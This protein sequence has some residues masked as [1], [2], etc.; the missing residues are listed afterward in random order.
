MSRMQQF[1]NKREKEIGI[2]ITQHV[3]CVFCLPRIVFLFLF[4][5]AYCELKQRTGPQ[6]QNL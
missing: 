1:L 5:L 4:F 2:Y 3:R 6:E